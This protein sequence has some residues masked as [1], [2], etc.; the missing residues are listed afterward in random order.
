MKLALNTL[1]FVSVV[2]SAFLCGCS[3]GD[4]STGT[5]SST[6]SNCPDTS[7]GSSSGGGTS[8]QPVQ[9]PPSGP[10]ADGVRP[11]ASPCTK[12]SGSSDSSGSGS[13]ASTD[14]PASGGSS[15]GSYGF[16]LGNDGWTCPSS[17]TKAACVKGSCGS[18]TKDP[19]QCSSDDGSGDPNP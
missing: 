13:S 14:K 9:T 1:A 11:Q 6:T 18:C 2:A 10:A 5:G 17:T 4:S 16:C 15:S 19:S 8:G 12:T 7:S 3:G